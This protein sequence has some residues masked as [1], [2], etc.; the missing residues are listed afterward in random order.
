VEIKGRKRK[1]KANK[2]KQKQTKANKSKQKQ[3]KGLGS[4]NLAAMP[5]Y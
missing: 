5:I 4:F 3:T 1:T 2:S